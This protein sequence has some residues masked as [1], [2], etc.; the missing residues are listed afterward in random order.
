MNRA[1]AGDD[2]AH[3]RLETDGPVAHLVLARPERR[4]AVSQP[5]LATMTKALAVVA[6]DDGLRALV[7]R[8]EGPDFCA[9]EDVAGFSFPDAEK[10]TAFL[11][12]P[13]GFFTALETLPK[14]VVA[15]VHGHALG[16]GS[17]VLFACDAVLADRDATFGFAE[18]DHGAVPSVLMTRGLAT[19]FRRR[20]LDLA[21]TGRR[22]GAE[23]AR[24]LRLVHEVVDDVHDAARCLALE[25]AERPSAS[26]RVVKTLL[27]A[28]AR[29]DHDAATE[30]MSRVLVQVR[31]T[32]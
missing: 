2:P 26:V 9:G 24:R 5:M 11:S 10:S 20:A 27:G 23:E 19:V 13:L 25:L 29:D 4:N 6:A 3:V 18:I 32:L 22:V 1:V 7:L 28:D 12:G 15:A 17:E 16:F 30:F 21:L 31:A 14:P 8:G